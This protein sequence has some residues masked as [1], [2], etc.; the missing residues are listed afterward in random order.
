MN[1]WLIA[2]AILTGLNIIFVP[3]TVS[4][5]RE[6][7][8]GGVASCLVVIHAAVLLCLLKAGGVL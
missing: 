7:I 8:T 4:R 6:P 1:S 2:P 5:R 3:W